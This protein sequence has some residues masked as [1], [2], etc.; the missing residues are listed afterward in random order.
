MRFFLILFS[1]T[2]LYANAFSQNSLDLEGIK[3]AALDTTSNFSYNSL[4][5][6]FN[7]IPSKLDI[8]KG[9]IIYYG[10]LFTP[11]YK[12]YKINFIAIDFIKLIS[13][14]KYK[15]AIS[16][17]EEILESDPANLE[18]LSGLAVCYSKAGLSDQ[19]N[20]TKAK[21]DLLIASILEHGRGE[22]KENTLKVVSTADEYILMQVLHITPLSRRSGPLGTSVLD[23]W[24][25]KDPNGKRI[26]F[27]VKV[28][29][30][31]SGMK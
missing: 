25:A 19:E 31:F 27:F 10:K 18:V 13:K 8:I 5:R 15:Q 6:K 30:E 2:L 23:I 14:K 20:L 24:K 29:Y 26:D 17:G 22:L 16:K 7:Q 28:I 4:V 11:D 1:I 3:R 21:L 9:T 12:P